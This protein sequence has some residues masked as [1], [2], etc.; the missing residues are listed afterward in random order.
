[1]FNKF[2]RNNSTIGC[3]LS[4]WRYEELVKAVECYKRM[5]DGEDNPQIKNTI[6]LDKYKTWQEEYSPIDSLDNNSFISVNEKQKPDFQEY[7]LESRNKVKISEFFKTENINIEVYD[8][9]KKKFF[10]FMKETYY[11]LR[12]T[13]MNW[14]VNRTFSDF[15]LLRKSLKKSFPFILVK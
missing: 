10:L 5:V 1:M 3:E 13:P 8:S 9:T 15:V 12:I 2:L 11:M 14:Q 7:E 4:E 6:N